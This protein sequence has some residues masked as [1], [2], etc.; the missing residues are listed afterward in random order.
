MKDGCTRR[1]T[2]KNDREVPEQKSNKVIVMPN[3]PTATPVADDQSA[4][5]LT[6]KL[7]TVVFF[8]E[9]P[10]DDPALTDEA[11]GPLYLKKYH[12]KARKLSF[13][14]GRAGTTVV[15]ASQ[16][17]RLIKL[18]T[19][20]HDGKFAV[21]LSKKQAAK[22]LKDGHQIKLSVFEADA[23]HLTQNLK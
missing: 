14:Q 22:L 23:D 8:P 9:T 7:E 6:N 19:V 12:R 5:T 16:N 13:R 1:M 10:A 11:G 15:I 3:Q 4:A 20:K 21:R 17:G 18:V 2:K